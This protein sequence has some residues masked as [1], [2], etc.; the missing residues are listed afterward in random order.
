MRVAREKPR[1]RKILTGAVIFLVLFTITGFFVV[2]AIL[3][4]VLTTKLSERL[5]RQVTIQKIKVNPFVLSADVKG[6]LVK[7]RGNTG[8]FVSFDEL[9]VNLQ[10]ASVWKR[11]PILKEIKIDHPYINV[12][13]NDDGTYN[14][15]DLLE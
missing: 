13:R 11:G 2:P 5:H 14:F 3:K 8:T 12:I 10:T 7:D 6:F 1:L 15:S 4:S 9:Y